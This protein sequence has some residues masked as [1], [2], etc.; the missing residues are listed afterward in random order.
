MQKLREDGEHLASQFG[1]NDG[2]IENIFD[3]IAKEHPKL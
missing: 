2:D 3:V 1:I